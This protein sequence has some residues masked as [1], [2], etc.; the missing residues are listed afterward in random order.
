MNYRKRN[1]QRK[2]G[3]LTFRN[4]TKYKEVKSGKG[5]GLEGRNGRGRK[6]NRE[7]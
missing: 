3:R 6:K 2:R 7:K 4:T 1:K 5:R